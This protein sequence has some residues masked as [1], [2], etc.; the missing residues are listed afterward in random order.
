M[1]GPNQMP[2]IHG[3]SELMGSQVLGSLRYGLYVTIN[4][5]IYILPGTLN[6]CSKSN[7]GMGRGLVR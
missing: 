2:R 5:L 3:P 6:I 4:V 1:K 7:A